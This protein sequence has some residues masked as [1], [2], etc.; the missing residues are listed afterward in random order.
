MKKNVEEPALAFGFTTHTLTMMGDALS[1]LW[2]GRKFRPCMNALELACLKDGRPGSGGMLLNLSR[3]FHELD[4]AFRLA[5]FL[6]IPVIGAVAVDFVNSYSLALCLEKEL[7][8]VIGE[9]K[10]RIELLEAR[11]SL[12]AGRR[13][14]ARS[15]L[16]NEG[17]RFI[18]FPAG[19][20][21]LSDKEALC[22]DGRLGG[23]SSKEISSLL[24]IT[25]SSVST[26]MSR[27]FR[28]LGVESG[29]ELVWCLAGRPGGTASYLRQRNRR[30]FPV[31]RPFPRDRGRAAAERCRRAERVLG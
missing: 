29:E 10:D 14:V 6:S 19:F 7:P 24:G 3:E 31:G 9:L 11:E 30:F 15:I 5:R 8:A 2:P 25:P 13:F 17:F 20:D 28:K 1:F 27:A 18:D 26:C 21:L 12:L 4:S 23:L 16:R 22:I